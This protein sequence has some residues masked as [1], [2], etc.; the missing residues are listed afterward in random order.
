[1]ADHETSPVAVTTQAYDEMAVK[2]MLIHA[3]N[4]GTQSMRDAGSMYLP[5]ETEEGVNQYDVR[6]DRSFL[7]NAYRDAVENIVAKPFSKAVTLTGAEDLPEQLQLIEEDTDRAGT[8]LTQFAREL[9]TIGINHG[10]AHV[11][12]DYPVTSAADG[13]APRLDEQREKGIRP[14]LIPVSPVAVIGWRGEKIEAT[15]AHELIQAR[16]VEFANEPDGDYGVKEVKRIRVLNREGFE[17]WV[18]DPKIENV[19][20]MESEGEY[21]GFDG[22]PLITGYISR[23]GFMTAVPALEDLAWLNLAHWQS[24]SDQ[25]SILRFARTGLW[26][27][28]GIDEEEMKKQKVT[29][30]PNGR[31]MTANADAKVSVV[32]HSG[33]AIGAGQADL[34][35]TEQQMQVLGL[36]PFFKLTG[37]ATA[38]EKIIDENR[39]ETEVQSWIRIVEKMIYNSYAMAAKWV[40]E[41]LP[42][43]FGVNIYSN[44]VLD[45]L[46]ARDL[47]MLLDMRVSGNLDEQ[48]FVEEVKRRGLFA[49]TTTAEEVIERVSAMGPSL[50]AMGGGMPDEEEE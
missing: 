8:S 20:T 29:L 27:F 50:A 3:L 34:D 26:V 32:E 1:M 11:W 9:L 16:M 43:S 12:V 6:L 33:S 4:G 31:F 24:S 28:T 41:K 37:G 49:E 40:N 22:V 36:Q 30:G 39:S 23:T 17:L 15:G 45:T 47:K 42:D 44:F 25:R 18:Q 21:V 10:L 7:F 38:T 35:K 48:T 13:E 5:Q 46:A 19:Y 2:W 14:L